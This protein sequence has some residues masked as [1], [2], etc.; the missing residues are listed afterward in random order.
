MDHAPSNDPSTHRSRDRQE[1]D[2]P[3]YARIRQMKRGD[4][5][6]VLANEILDCGLVGHMG[7]VADERPMVIPMAYARVGD[8]LYVH[9][10]STT[11]LIKSQAG[12]L[13]VSFTVTHLEGLVVARA[14]FNLSMNYRCAIVHGQATLVEDLAEKEAS[15]IAITDHMLPGRWSESRPMLPKELK[16][17]GVLRLTMDHVSTKVR[18]GPPVDEDEDLGLPIW[19]GVIPVTSALGQPLAAADVPDTVTA[20]ASLQAARKKFA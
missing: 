18:S 10:A 17:T 14:A 6:R 1:P 15:L 19:A 2:R 20:P 8:V 12:G 16:A 3:A 4:Y 9:G 13:P 5:D 7:F 11:R